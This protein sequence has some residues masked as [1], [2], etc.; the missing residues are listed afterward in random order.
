MEREG[1]IR[2]SRCVALPCVVLRCVALCCVVLRCV[3]LVVHVHPSDGIGK[4][5]VQRALSRSPPGIAAQLVLPHVGSRFRR[6]QFLV[7]WIT[8]YVCQEHERSNGMFYD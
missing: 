4:A 3:A 1:G 2:N 7:I 8:T 5:H 6:G